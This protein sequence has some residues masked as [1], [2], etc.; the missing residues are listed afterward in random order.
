MSAFLAFAGG[1]I[2]G[3]IAEIVSADKRA[4]NWEKHGV[5]I[6]HHFSPRECAVV[7]RIPA[8]ISL[9][10]HAHN[11]DHLSILASGSA[12]VVVDGVRT[13]HEGPAVLTVKAGAVHT[14]EA[15]TDVFWVCCHGVSADDQHDLE[16][17]VIS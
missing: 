1:P 8:G 10:Q 12:D 17:Q 7:A 2:M 15:V 14:V 9:P 4:E 11:H 13:R 6:E 3:H 5:Q 16:S